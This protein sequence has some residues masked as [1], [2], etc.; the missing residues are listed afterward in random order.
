VAAAAAVIVAD[1]V[2][3]VGTSEAAAFAADAFVAFAKW[4]WSRA[5]VEARFDPEEA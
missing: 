1:A 5:E 2:V 4:T 3:A